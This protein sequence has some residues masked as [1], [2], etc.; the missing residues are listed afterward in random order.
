[1]DYTMDVCR[2]S[3]W[4]EANIMHK[5]DFEE[6]E[7]VVGYSYP[8]ICDFFKQVTNI[9][10]SRYISARKVANAAF[11]IRH[12]KQNITMIAENFD[13]SNVDTFT[14][15]F[16]RVT[17]LTPSQFKK[18]DYLCGR[19]IICPSVFAPVI[20]NHQNPI[21]TLQ[22]IKEVNVMS[23]MKETANSRVLYGVP[24]VYWERELDGEIQHSPFPMCLQSVLSYM[25]Q[26]IRY[27]QLLVATGAVFRQRWY[28]KGWSF[29]A[30]DYRKIYDDPDKP[31]ALAFKAAGR[32][33]K[34]YG[35]NEKSKYLDVIKSELDCGR[36]VIALGV[37]GPPEPGIVTGYRENGETLLG[38]SLFQDYEDCDTDEAGYFIKNDWLGGTETI[39]SI[40]EEISVLAT[41][42]EILENAYMLMTTDKIECYHSPDDLHYGAQAAYEA[43]AAM[44]ESADYLN[45]M[46]EGAF[47]ACQCDQ[48]GMLESRAYAATYMESL[49]GKYPHLAALLKKCAR[50]LK[51]A[52]DC[53]TE[54]RTLREDH[55][56]AEF[57]ASPEHRTQIATLI[58]K[59]ATHEKDA[60]IVLGEVLN[61]V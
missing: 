35:E 27:S 61:K 59:A 11:E 46:D 41:D 37:V 45:G 6:M 1:M 9:S 44:L 57:F 25:G 50:L 53:A 42:K 51:S 60:C 48:E 15:V 49:A 17:G 54:M 38:W 56:F 29:A 23:E 8:H 39:M 19:Q 32:N 33:Y 10:L 4:I 31:F 47:E 55:N 3:A 13:F 20:L 52:A 18:S 24:K 12:S 43:W 22:H 16:K 28:H 36:P 21:F 40:S 26:E 7:K 2:V 58:R 30:V 34:L 14:R 5:I